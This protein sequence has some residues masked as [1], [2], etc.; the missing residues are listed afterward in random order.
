LLLHPAFL[1]TLTSF[2]F[3]TSQCTYT[4]TESTLKYQGGERALWLNGE[5]PATE[6]NRDLPPKTTPFSQNK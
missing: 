1:H 4:A 2:Q 3:Q 5:N 6:I